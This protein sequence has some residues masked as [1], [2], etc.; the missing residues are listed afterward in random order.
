MSLK[1]LLSSKFTWSDVVS[2]DISSKFR[3]N[4]TTLGPTVPSAL[5]K[6]TTYLL[7]Q[8]KQVMYFSQYFNRSAL[9]IFVQVLQEKVCGGI[10]QAITL[11]FYLTYRP[12]AFLYY[13][14]Q[15]NVSNDKA[16]SRQ[17]PDM[18]CATQKEDIF[19]S[20][21]GNICQLFICLVFTRLWQK[22][23]RIRSSLLVV[24]GHVVRRPVERGFPGIAKR[25][26][27]L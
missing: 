27:E 3:S 10:M 4:K 22:P 16:A 1:Q 26:V 6:Q 17:A 15:R 18:T 24:L 14:L 7:G 8:S 5:N 12:L 25:F 21:A 11:D 20:S 2:H 9:S 19:T 13:S 23:S